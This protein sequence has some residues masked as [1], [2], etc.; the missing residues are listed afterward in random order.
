MTSNP[1]LK[2]DIQENIMLDSKPMTVQG[3]INKTLI[4]AVLVALVA[5]YSFQL[6]LSGFS[7]KAFMMA[8]VG[9]IAGFILALV[10]FF[11][12]TVAKITAPIYALCEGLVVGSIS[13]AYNAIY[14]GIVPQ[15]VGITLLA[16]FVMLFLYKTKVI[17]ATPVF[18][19]VVITS[20]VAIAVFY[21][22]GIIAS[23]FGHPMTVFNG[24][25]IGI[26]IT[27]LFCI[28]AS[29]NFI[30]DFDFIEKG[31]QAPLPDY[32]EWYGAL[33]LMVTVIWLYFE[34]LRLLAQLNRR[35]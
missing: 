34:V 11:K 24:S 6:C 2:T 20:T 16:L 13:F 7:D 9:A 35:N 15:A 23:L 18:T 22:V 21:L 1:M 5:V 8:S 3:A 26:G 30:L 29:L 31:A 25:L 12:P 4:L 33:S 14:D 28:I 32:F 27:V 17:Q 10:S 19:K